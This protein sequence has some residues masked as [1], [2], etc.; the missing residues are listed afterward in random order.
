MGR[1][2]LSTHVSVPI[3]VVIIIIIIF[4]QFFLLCLPTNETDVVKLIEKYVEFE[5]DKLAI[6]LIE[7]YYSR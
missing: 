5:Y 1:C 7:L 3:V 4:I 6:L 2:S